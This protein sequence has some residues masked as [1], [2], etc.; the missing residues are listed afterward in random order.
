MW[1]GPLPGWGR[2]RRL[3]AAE[4]GGTAACFLSV[5]GPGALLCP[6]C[7][8]ESLGHTWKLEKG[9]EEWMFRSRAEVVRGRGRQQGQ[10]ALHWVPCAYFVTLMSA[11]GVKKFGYIHSN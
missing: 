4:G 6:P 3:A 7:L 8:V 2:E 1:P 9:W 10:D 11:F 5:P